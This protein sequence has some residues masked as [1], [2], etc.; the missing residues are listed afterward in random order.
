VW[1]SLDDN[2]MSDLWEELPDKFASYKES[3]IHNTHSFI[4]ELNADV[5]ALS[6][7]VVKARM[8]ER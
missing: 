3:K 2:K 7:P 6:D 4:D 8:K 5:V 1:S